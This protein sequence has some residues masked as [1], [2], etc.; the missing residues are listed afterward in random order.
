MTQVDFYILDSA[1]TGQRAR[2]A[3]RLIDKAYRLQRQIYVHTEDSQQAQAIDE[4]LW[5][6]RNTS[7]VPHQLVESAPVNPRTP[8]VIGCDADPGDHRDVMVNLALSVPDFFS[9]FE[10]VAEVV[11]QVPQVKEATRQHYKLYRTRGCSLNTH[12]IRTD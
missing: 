7:F 12:N 11:V 8:V 6:F 9:R 3:C 1:D 5:S 2:F 10:R 4:M